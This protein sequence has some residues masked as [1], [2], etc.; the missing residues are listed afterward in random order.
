MSMNT[1]CF[2]KSRSLFTGLFLA[3]AASLCSITAKAQTSVGVYVSPEI[4]RAYN[5]FNEGPAK[6]LG[7]TVGI[8]VQTGLS[9]RI[10]FI[11]GVHYAA[12][13]FDSNGYRSSINIGGETSL[14]N[15]NSVRYA[16][17]NFEVPLQV[18]YGFAE[19][20]SKLTPYVQAGIVGIWTAS[21]KNKYTTQEGTT[22]ETKPNISGSRTNVSG[23]GGIGIAYRINELLELNVQ[24]TIRFEFDSPI[25]IS[26]IGLG[27]ALFYKF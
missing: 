27:T 24:P 5:Y 13:R 20:T 12:K 17:Q 14:T 26:R 22:F 18:R 19:K 6:D 8:S 3:V 15:V 23:E 1:A 25:F 10:S 7:A 4:N 9:Q 21:A 16:S 11:Y 2:N